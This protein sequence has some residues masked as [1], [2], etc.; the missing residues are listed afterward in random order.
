MKEGKED[1]EEEKGRYGQRREWGQ[2]ECDMR[3]KERE[4]M[5]GKRAC[6]MGREETWNRTRGREEL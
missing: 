3:R 4:D 2:M 6:G 5:G 1:L